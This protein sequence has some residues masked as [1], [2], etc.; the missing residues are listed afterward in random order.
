M[1]ELSQAQLQELLNPEQARIFRIVHKDNMR[2]ILE[3]GVH[4]SSSP[5]KAP[6]YTSIG[7]ADI[8]QMRTTRTV[9]I[10]PGGVLSDYI[11]LYFTPFSPMAYNIKTGFNGIRR[12][13]NSEIVVLVS[14]LPRLVEHAVPFV[15]AD[16]H[17]YLTAARFSSD[18]GALDRI[19]WGILQRKDFRRDNDDL[20]KVERYQA[21]ALVHKRI[22][23]SALL[24]VACY[25]DLVVDDI[26]A[27]GDELRVEVI[28]RSRPAWYFA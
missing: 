26:K 16:R 25:D 27:L 8:I 13:D 1:P 12:R 22:A 9:P 3:N 18:L 20:G 2:W 6:E 14:S 7:N 23:I 15:F 4:C 21:E 24:G 11:P 5:D 17:A 10:P 19:D 28:V